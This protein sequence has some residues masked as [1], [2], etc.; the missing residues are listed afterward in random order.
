MAAVCCFTRYTVHRGVPMTNRSRFTKYFFCP[1]AL[2]LG[3]MAHAQSDRTHAVGGDGGGAFD[4][5]CPRYAYLAGFRFRIGDDMDAVSP[6]CAAISESGARGS[7]SPPSAHAFAGTPNADIR[8]AVCPDAVRAPFVKRLEVHAEGTRIQ[9]VNGIRFWCGPANGAE[10][11][12]AYEARGPKARRTST[13]SIFAGSSTLPTYQIVACP[14]GQASAGI[15]GRAGLFVDALGLVCRGVEVQPLGSRSIAGTASPQGGQAGNVASAAR[16]ATR[17]AR[18][19]ITGSA[20][21][22]SGSNATNITETVMPTRDRTANP[23][24]NAVTGDIAGRIAVNQVICR[25]GSTLGLHPNGPSTTSA[26]PANT[27][28]LYFSP[29]RGPAQADASGLEPGQCGFVDRPWVAGDPPGIQFDVPAGAAGT[30]TPEQYLRDTTHY[31]SFVV[32][33]TGRGMFVASRNGKYRDSAATTTITEKPDCATN[34]VGMRNDL[35]SRIE[36]IRCENAGLTP[37][38]RVQLNS[39]LDEVLRWLAQPK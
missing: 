6:V 8:E 38:Q 1:F 5:Q 4:I 24:G 34:L 39:R 28:T 21:S 19:R 14:N 30:A 22:S 32:A 29:A 33:N 36:R 11:G 20:D 18:T 16:P 31:W 17:L 3:T 15:H 23:V 27:W 26:A 35:D 13:R 9:I 25:G 7:L 12:P 37:D 2:L 10:V